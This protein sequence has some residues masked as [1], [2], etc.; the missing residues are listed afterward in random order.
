VP[1]LTLLG[2]VITSSISYH[3]NA[4]VATAHAPNHVIREY[5]VNNNNIFGIRDPD[6]PNTTF[7]GLRRRLRVVYF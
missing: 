4:Y 5:G 1:P 6:L 7:I 2:N 3:K